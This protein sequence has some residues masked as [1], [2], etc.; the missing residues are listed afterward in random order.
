MVQM[1]SVHTMV[2]DF[3]KYLIYLQMMT[4]YQNDTDANEKLGY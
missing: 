1:F 2:S 3:V 4:I